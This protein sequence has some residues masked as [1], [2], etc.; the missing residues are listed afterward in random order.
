MLIHPTGRLLFLTLAFTIQAL[1]IAD[2]V[3]R[4]WRPTGQVAIPVGQVPAS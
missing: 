4:D 1:L 3:A 2:F